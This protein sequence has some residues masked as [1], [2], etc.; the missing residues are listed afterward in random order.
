MITIDSKKDCCG[1]TACQNA[2]PKNCITMKADTDGFLYPEIDKASC[3]DCGKCDK[4]CP[5]Q[6]REPGRKPAKKAYILRNNDA[7]V[8]QNSTSGGAVSAFC[9]SVVAN[10]GIVFGVVFDKSFRVVHKGIDNSEE[11]VR[12]RGS[13]YVQSDLSG[14]F[15]QVKEQ[16]KTGRQTMFIGTPCQVAGLIRYLG[17][18]YDNL[19]TIDFVCHAVPSPLVWELYKSTMEK[20]Y[21]SKITSVNFRE[22]TFGYHSSTIALTFENGKKSNENT[23]T[24]YMMKS[25]FDSISTRPSC[26]ECAFRRPDRVSDLTVFDC[27]NI[28]RYVPE[29]ADDDKGYTAVLVHTD[30]GQAM[31]DGVSDKTVSYK[32]DFDLLLQY[33]GV[34]AVKNPPIHPRRDEFFADLNN[35]VSLEKAVKTYIPVKLSRKAFGKTKTVLYRLGILKLMKRMKSGGK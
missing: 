11:L 2:C 33:C 30:K 26:H 10:G 27:W 25:F 35:G 3:I 4:I 14:I 31:L 9:G 18:P 7:S 20:K 24:D 32:A 29:V 17:K 6:N 12:F 22:K 28:T 13:K 21:N 1:C 8:V 23:L 5:V 16:L 19:I 15:V 34:M